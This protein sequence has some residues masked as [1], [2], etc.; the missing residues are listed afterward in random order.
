[1]IRLIDRRAATRGSTILA[2]LLAVGCHKEAPS[3]K[4]LPPPI[5]TVA[6]PTIQDVVRYESFNGRVEAVDDVEIRAKIY[7]FLKKVYFKPGSEVKKGDLLFEIYSD[8]YAAEL[9]RAE[10]EVSV[11]EARYKQKLAEFNR[12][13][14][15]KNNISQ[16]EYDLALAN[17]LESAGLIETSKAKK[18][19]AA[20]NV[21]Y[22]KITAP[23]NGIVGD[24]L[25]SEGSLV[26]GGQGNTT[27]LT[28]LVAV[29]PI[30]IAFDVD[31]NTLQR[32]QKMIRE[33]KLP[34]SDGNAVPIEAGIA[35]HGNEYPLKG[36]LDFLNN[37]IDPK[38]GTLRI[39]AR[40]P[41]PVINGN[42]VLTPG[43][44]ARGRLPL[45]TPTP[46]VVVPESALLSDQAD[47][48]LYAV[49]AD[50]K[51]VRLNVV[52]GPQ[53]GTKRVIESVRA[54]GEEAFRPLKVEDTIIVDGLQRVRPGLV[55]EPKM[56]A[57]ASK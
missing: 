34:K 17:K 26:S 57:P 44:F 2:I 8:Q 1:M 3:R 35:V 10:A 40:F 20:L 47:R 25:V 41:N 21:S 45:G 56:Q 36:Q 16:A 31:E 12:A 4:E 14:A 23:M 22:C 9:A 30:D 54:V 46:Q 52:L 27:L 7:G 15:L 18:T 43:M 49:T 37:K 28:T 29:D 51:A 48:Y 38:T 42:R 55:V 39:K 13:E 6:H 32:L 5:V 33:G 24:N 11:A 50:N 19:N 53:V